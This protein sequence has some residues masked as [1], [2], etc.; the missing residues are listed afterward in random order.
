VAEKFSATTPEGKV[1]LVKPGRLRPKK[2]ES[3]KRQAGTPSSIGCGHLSYL[4]MAASTK[5]SQRRRQARAIQPVRLMV[6][7]R[8]A[9][10]IRHPAMVTIR[11]TAAGIPEATTR[12][13]ILVAA[14]VEGAAIS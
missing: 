7:R 11:R 6:N 12:E 13:E 3:N 1:V 8:K 10:S 14:V 2:K 9:T 5:S 4:P